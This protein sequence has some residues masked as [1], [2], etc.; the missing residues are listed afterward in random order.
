[1]SSCPRASLRSSI[2]KSI[3][4]ELYEDAINTH[5]DDYDRRQEIESWSEK[6]KILYKNLDRLIDYHVD[7]II[8]HVFQ[9]KELQEIFQNDDRDNAEEIW[10]QRFLEYTIKAIRYVKPSQRIMN[11]SM[12][13]NDYVEIKLIEYDDDSK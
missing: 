13:I 6:K 8:E 2:N 9:E 11:D 1:M 4:Q 5:E 12:D 7:E 3:K 10:K